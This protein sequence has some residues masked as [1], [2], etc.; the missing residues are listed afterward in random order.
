MD[1]RD[2]PQYHQHK[3]HT[4]VNAAAVKMYGIRVEVAQYKY[5]TWNRKNSLVNYNYSYIIRPWVARRGGAFRF[6]IG[7][8]SCPS[9]RRTYPSGRFGGST[10]SVT[11]RHVLC[12]LDNEMFATMD[13]NEP[14]CR[15][16]DVQQRLTRRSSLC[17]WYCGVWPVTAADE[18]EMHSD[19]NTPTY[20]LKEGRRDMT[21]QQTG[22]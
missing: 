22:T 19:R 15:R 12:S 5:S 9:S 13:P 18:D 1:R 10:S 21:L 6:G 2:C 8:R 14:I 16:I 20:H 7:V 17:T 3:P 11:V 4:T